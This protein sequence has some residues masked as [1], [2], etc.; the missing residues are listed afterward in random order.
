MKSR[1]DVENEI[2]EIVNRE[3][4]AWDTKD[5]AQLITIFHPDMVWPWPPSGDAH[6]PVKWVFV[7]GR[8]DAQRWANVWQ[9]LFDTHSLGTWTLCGATAMAKISIGKG[10]HARST[11]AWERSGR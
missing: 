9:E 5:V 4:R 11:A 2:T 1:A 6:D 8:F 10:V 3:T 7:M